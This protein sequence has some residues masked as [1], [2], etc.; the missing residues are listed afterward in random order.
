[1]V[2]LSRFPFSASCFLM[3][4]FM[5]L[6]LTARA[7]SKEKP[8][9]KPSFQTAIARHMHTLNTLGQ[10][11][12]S[13]DVDTVI[14]RM[15]REQLAI[16]RTID[17]YRE[18]IMQARDTADYEYIYLAK[19]SDKNFCL[20]SW[21]TRQGGTMIEYATTAIYRTKE[22]ALKTKWLVEKTSSL[23]N[24]LMHYDQV[25]VI[26]SDKGTLYLAHGFGQGST[27]LPWQELAAFR[28]EGNTLVQPKIFPGSKSNLFVEFD[29]HEF[30]D[31]KRI[32]TIK[33]Q[34]KGHKILYP[35]PTDRE[36]FTG[37]Y[38]TYVFTGRTYKPIGR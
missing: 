10:F 20:L 30:S 7:Q 32:P 38:R 23:K 29:T 14:N 37:R 24:T 2:S 33:V 17:R 4:T 21:D 26:R 12:D 11:P 25:H 31:G 5:F 19:A 8:R 22:G 36:G 9:A 27:A 1:M 28:V 13:L 6:G 35:I 15:E 34:E 18:E 16:V 3:M